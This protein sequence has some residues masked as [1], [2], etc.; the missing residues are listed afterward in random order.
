MTNKPSTT[1]S[2]TSAQPSSGGITCRYTNQTAKVQ[3]IR[4]SNVSQG[5]LERT[6]FPG[7]QLLF[8]IQSDA[9]LEV[10][11]YET[12]TTILSDRIP[13]TQLRYGE[14]LSSE[15][16]SELVTS[17]VSD[18]TVIEKSQRAVHIRRGA[19]R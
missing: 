9:F 15:Q 17:I 19:G 11:T 13:C 6:V 4:T 7:S 12:P 8:D 3:I 1:S 14:A 16:D 5:T 10:S 18:R 2:T